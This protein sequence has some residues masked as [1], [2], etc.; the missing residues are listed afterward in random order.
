MH[1][2]NYLKKVRK[3][4]NRDEIDKYYDGGIIYF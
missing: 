3:S 4:E 2:K 1:Q